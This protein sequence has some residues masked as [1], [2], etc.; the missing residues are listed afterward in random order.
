[1]DRRLR[2]TDALVVSIDPDRLACGRV[3][4]RHVAARPRR[5]VQDTPDHDRR[6][7]KVVVGPRAEIVGLPT[8]G[9]AEVLDVVAV[10]LIERRVLRAARIGAVISP[11]DGLRS[12][13]GR[14]HD[15]PGKRDEGDAERRTH[16]ADANVFQRY[17]PDGGVSPADDL[18]TTVTFAPAVKL[19]S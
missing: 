9:D 2:R 13:L 6:R 17:C 19:P 4:R 14:R 7:L 5:R 11:F 1:A 18:T 3:D 8:P 10:D 15:R 16:P 12:V